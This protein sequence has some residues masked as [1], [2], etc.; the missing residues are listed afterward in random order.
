[1]NLYGFD[2]PPVHFRIFSILPQFSSLPCRHGPCQEAGE[3]PHIK[4][5]RKDPI[6][7]KKRKQK[8]TDIV[9]I[10]QER[11]WRDHKRSSLSSAK[12]GA[13]TNAT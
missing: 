13:N 10:R 9:L 11:I 6:N 7:A 8:S 3:S 1:M 2:S 5:T 4:S 12:E